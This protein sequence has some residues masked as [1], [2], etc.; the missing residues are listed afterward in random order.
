[1]AKKEKFN[2]IKAL[3]ERKKKDKLDFEVAI[4][5]LR[6]QDRQPATCTY[7]DDDGVLL[8]LI[9]E[10]KLQEKVVELKTEEIARAALMKEK[11]ESYIG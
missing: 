7:C 9:H 3:R 2:L 4:V 10:G 5:A 11:D 8:R 1:M 6:F